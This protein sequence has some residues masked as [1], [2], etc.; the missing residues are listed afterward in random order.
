VNLRNGLPPSVTVVFVENRSQSPLGFQVSSDERKEIDAF[1][2]SQTS[3]L[4]LSRYNP[5][6]QALRSF[7]NRRIQ[8]WEGHTRLE[9]DKLVQAVTK[10]NGDCSL[11][12]SAICSF[13]GRIGTGFSASAFGTQFEKEVRD[14]CARKAKGKPAAIQE[15]GRLLLAEPNHRGVA[16]VLCRISEFAAKNP[17]FSN[18][19][20]G[21]YKEFWEAIRLGDY[22][23][24]EIGL[25]EITHRRAYSRPKP[26]DKAISTIHK[27]KGLE[28]DSTILLHCD[29]KSFP[30][31]WE[32]RCLLYVALSRAKNRLMIVAS[33]QYPSPL[34]S[35]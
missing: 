15:L 1:E 10:A 8:L 2:K 23:T 9:L 14:G 25:A 32:A 20:I 5:T 18:I 13:M 26:P 24:P 7:F 33:R 6:T 31:E 17:S 34:L 35:I 21:R 30:D 19:K 29:A 22:E 28:C 16:K 4:I 11:L 12:V 27:A 3:L